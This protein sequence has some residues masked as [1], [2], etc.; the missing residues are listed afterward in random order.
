MTLLRDDPAAV[1]RPKRTDP[2]PVPVLLM[3]GRECN[4]ELEPQALPA[5]AGLPRLPLPTAFFSA[6]PGALTR[7]ATPIRIVSATTSAAGPT[8]KATP[9]AQRAA[10]AAGRSSKR[11]QTALPSS[12]S[13]PARPP[14]MEAG[15]SSS[16]RRVGS[17]STGGHSPSREPSGLA[18]AVSTRKTTSTGPGSRPTSGQCQGFSTTTQPIPHSQ[19]TCKSSRSNLSL[20]WHSCNSWMHDRDSR[21]TSCSQALSAEARLQCHQNRLHPRKR[22]AQFCR[23]RG[24]CRSAA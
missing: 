12:P 9:H 1:Q 6:P 5:G 16:R 17:P 2:W 13:A 7:S 22:P 24:V 19:F 18:S 20:S 23:A 15:S 14:H 4:V 3:V 11:P 8:A 21:L 10:G